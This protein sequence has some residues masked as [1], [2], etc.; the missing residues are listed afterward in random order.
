MSKEAEI[1]PFHYLLELEKIC[2]Q[3]Y[4]E[5]IDCLNSYATKLICYRPVPKSAGTVRCMIKRYNEGIGG[6]V[7]PK[8]EL[9]LAVIWAVPFFRIRTNCCWLA[10]ED[11]EIGLET[12][13]LLLITRIWQ[14]KVADIAANWDQTFGEAAIIC[15]TVAKILLRVPRRRSQ[16]KI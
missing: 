11:P 16:E 9:V 12:I 15:L 2:M 4:K 3:S 6:S 8:F 10:R 7:Y 14:Q 5:Q 1:L 13:W